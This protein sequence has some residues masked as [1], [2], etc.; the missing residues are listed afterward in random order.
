MVIENAETGTPVGEARA[1]A[2]QAASKRG[3]FGRRSA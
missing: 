2:P 1:R 3:W